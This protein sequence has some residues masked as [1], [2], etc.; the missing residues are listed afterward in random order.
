[1]E[2]TCSGPSRPLVDGD[3]ESDG[4]NRLVLAAGLTAR[5]VTVVRAYGKYLRQIG[6]AFSQ[7]YIEATLHS[8]PRL[9]ADL[10][11]LFHARFDPPRYRDDPLDGAARAAAEA[12]IR[13]RL[14]AAL[15][16]IPSLDDDRI[17]RMFLTLIDATV[18]T[19]YYRDRPALSFKF[20]PSADP[21]A[22]PAPAPPRD[23]GVRPAGRG[24]APAR[25]ADR[26]RRAAV[27]RPPGGLPHRGPRADEGPDGQERR[28][29]A[30]GRQGRVRRQAAAGRRRGAAGRGRRVLPDLH[31]QPARPHRQ[32]GRRRRV[33]HP[34]D[35]VVHDGDDT[36]FVVAADKGTATFSD[37]ANEIS[38]EYGYWLGDAFAS[39]GSAGYD[40]KAM[41]ITARGAWESVRRHASVLGKDAD[42]DPLTAVG[43]GDMS[44]DVFGNGMLRSRA[45]RLVAAFDHRHVF[46]DPD[47]DPEVAFDERQRLFELPRS[48][49]ADYDPSLIS[50]GGGGVRP[51]PEV[52]PA[53][54]RGAS[55]A[56][57]PGPPV[58]AERARQRRAQGAGRPAVER[59]HRHVRQGRHRDQRRRRR[60]GQRRASAST[61]GTCGRGWSARAAT[62]G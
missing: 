41:G 9:V 35:T 31:P 15:D 56:G 11:A 62:S 59:R 51:H 54:P 27:E 57:R 21:R 48:S 5:E 3:V 23:L 28:D 44:G 38:A 60:P 7:P 40:H 39:G 4:F 30:D 13:E 17:C 45:L 26:P 46:I 32:P 55:R 58:D 16:A 8:H 1:M 61:D 25:R 34:P 29:R 10:V 19:N 42:T 33:V 43:I 24:R 20:D 36:Y 37:V 6:F 52:D 2:P 50:A 53:E 18:R 12:E 47:P 49:W 14:V 22:A